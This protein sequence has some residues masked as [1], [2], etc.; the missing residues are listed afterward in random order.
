MQMLPESMARA[1]RLG[2]MCVELFLDMD[3]FKQVNDTRGH[4]EG[5]ELLRQFATRLLDGIRETGMASRL[6]GD[7]FVVVLDMLNDLG[8]AEA[9][10]AFLLNQLTRPFRLAGGS[11]SV[12][13]S[14]GLA[15]Q[16]PHEPQDPTRLLAR[17]DRCTSQN[18]RGRDASPSRPPNRESVTP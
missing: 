11:V 2:R 14:I 1:A 12:G 4:E 8:E 6:A 18:A 5:D 16:L 3:G 7:E 17:A 10:A 9:K 13:A 15:L